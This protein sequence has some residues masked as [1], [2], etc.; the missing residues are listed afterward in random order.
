MALEH[1]GEP[2]TRALQ[3]AGIPGRAGQH[4]GA[5]QGREHQFVVAG[6]RRVPGGDLR[7]P[8]VH[9]G[10]GERSRSG[11]STSG[12]YRGSGHGAADVRAVPA[13]EFGVAGEKC[14]DDSRRGPVRPGDGPVEQGRE[15]LTIAVEAGGD[16]RFLAIRE[17]M[18]EDPFG[19]AGFAADLLHPGPADP[20]PP[21]EQQRGVHQGRAGG[22][23]AAICGHGHNTSTTVRTLWSNRGVS[24]NDVPE[25]FTAATHVDE[26]SPG[27]F[28]TVISPEW[29]IGGKPNGGYLLAILARAA[30]AV[31]AHDHVLA[32]SAHYLRAPDPG[33]AA[34]ETEV[35]RTGRSASQ[36]RTRLTQDG[37]P[38]I[39]ALTTIGTLEADTKPYW[40]DGLPTPEVHDRASGVRLPGTTPAGVPVAIM[41]RV[42]LR[43]DREDASFGIGK[44]R[45]L[46]ELNGWLAL[47]GGEDF[48]PISLVFA[49]DAFPPATFDIEPT[50]WV[51][52][53]ELTAY[54]RA[55]PAPGPVRVQQKARLIDGQKVDEACFVWDSTGR[56][57]AQATQLA[58]IRLG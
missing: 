37:K 9:G 54:V 7:A 2:V 32:A 45:G 43:I 24:H 36:V 46:G 25:T 27:R 10:R 8:A 17:V 56:L 6:Q 47:R 35:L 39:E 34:V 38:C 22:G 15:I 53:L 40:T 3:R 4:Q 5:F 11:G 52:T 49:V 1:L 23:A 33:P 55:L 21:E 14:P 18:G 50:G 13:H 16:Q 19:H 48:D 51:P 30:T 20:L 26:T 42:D 41:D 31:S 44:P 58:G 28:D 12:V 57:V 29:T